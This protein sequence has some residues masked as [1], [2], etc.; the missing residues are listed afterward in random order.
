MSA[1]THVP[2]RDCLGKGWD[3]VRVL[4]VSSAQKCRSCAG[5]GALAVKDAPP[6]DALTR[7]LR[8]MGVSR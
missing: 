3:Y 6:D 7:A 5:T 4:G 8:L 1:P 2:C